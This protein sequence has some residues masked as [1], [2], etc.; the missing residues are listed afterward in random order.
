MGNKRL[1]AKEILPLVPAHRC[2]CEPFAGSAAVLLTKD[3]S[4]NEVLNDLNGDLINFYRIVRFHKDELVRE[5]WHMPVSRSEFYD[6]KAQPGL[7][8]IQRA[9]RWFYRNKFG[10]GGKGEHFGRT[11]HRGPASREGLWWRLEA[12]CERLQDVI[13]ENQDWRSIFGFYDS[14]ETFFFIDPPYVE[15]EQYSSQRWSERDHVE[16]A[17]SVLSLRG[18]WVLTYN[19]HD[20]VRRL[21]DGTPLREVSQA[22][23]LAKDAKGRSHRMY[24]VIISPLLPHGG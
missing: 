23:Q 18:S 19:D 20:L 15:T 8:D 1:M 5:L 10:F 9:A 7:T 3:P 24:Q 11:K 21:Y 22:Q 14:S 4:P 12:L 17:E 16:L 13:L 6:A 2:Y